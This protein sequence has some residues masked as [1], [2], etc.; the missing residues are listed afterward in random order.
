MKNRRQFIKATSAT[1]ALMAVCSVAVAV[2][3]IPNRAQKQGPQ[4]NSQTFAQLVN[5]E[6][7]VNVDDRRSVPVVLH[8]VKTHQYDPRLETFTLHFWGATSQAFRQGTYR[9]QHAR[10]GILDLFVVAHE[11]NGQYQRYEV[12]FNRFV[13]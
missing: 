6:F 5:S 9:F 8:S 4:L 11:H 7:R 3:G 13:A 2:P 12:T 1:A 10:L